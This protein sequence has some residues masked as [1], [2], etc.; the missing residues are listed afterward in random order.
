MHT[1]CIT[2]L[3]G[4]VVTPL[5]GD[6]W[7]PVNVINPSSKPVTLR[8]NCKLADIYPCIAL[9]DFDSDCSYITEGHSADIQ[10]NV[11][12]ADNP[13]VAVRRV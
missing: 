13:S 4:R 5:W 1:Q 10:C 7:V 8:C 9:E 12:K 11:A 2:V 3:V 6:S